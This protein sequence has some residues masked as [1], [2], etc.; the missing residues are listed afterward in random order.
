MSRSANLGAYLVVPQF[1]IRGLSGGR[2]LPKRRQPSG[3]ILRLPF[4]DFFLTNFLH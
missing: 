4:T 1:E 3:G 2:R